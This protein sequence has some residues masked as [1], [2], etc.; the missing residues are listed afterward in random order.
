MPTWTHGRK[1]RILLDEFDVSPYF[2]E[3]GRTNAADEVDVTTFGANDY[4]S[5]IGG[6]VG[7]SVDLSGF[8]E[9]ETDLG[10]MTLDEKLDDILAVEVPS[11]V[12]TVA[13][14][15]FTVGGKVSVFEATEL[16]YEITGG[17]GDAVRTSATFSAKSPSKSGWLLHSPDAAAGSSPGPTVD[18]NT[19]RTGSPV[20]GSLEGGVANLHVL[21]NGRAGATNFKVQHSDDGTTW[22]DLIT[23]DSVAAGDLAYQRKVVSGNVRRRLR[24]SWDGAGTVRFAIAFARL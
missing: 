3:A 6:F 5:Y 13:H 14:G 23:F 8:F 7:A 10:G 2:N 20:G 1:T 21:E 22:V 19:G 4:K 18:A 16:T 24:A 17:I 12:L 9:N 15:G 11:R